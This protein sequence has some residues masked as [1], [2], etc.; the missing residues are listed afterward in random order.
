[1]RRV[2][3]ELTDVDLAEEHDVIS[4]FLFTGTAVA[5]PTVIAAM[6]DGVDLCLSESFTAID[7]PKTHEAAP[8]RLCEQGVRELGLL[9]EVACEPLANV[10]AGERP[11]I[12]ALVMSRL[13]EPRALEVLTT[14]PDE[15]QCQ[16]LQRWMTLDMAD[17]SL[18]QE[19]EEE[20]R[21]RVDRQRD[22]GRRGASFAQI[23]GVVQA[24]KPV[25]T[26]E[27][28]REPGSF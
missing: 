15:L 16:V 10:L 27:T 23:A 20:L 25:V 26:A 2:I 6:G 12:I 24:A 17:S 14:L 13:S 22:D 19:I 18:A 8:M 21:A 3:V 28:A 9:D 1:M 4:E 5:D 7:E 11:Q